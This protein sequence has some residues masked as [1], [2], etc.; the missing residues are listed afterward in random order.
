MLLADGLS[1]NLDKAAPQRSIHEIRKQLYDNVSKTV[2][3]LNETANM[4]LRT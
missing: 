1:N 4:D 2:K 3:M